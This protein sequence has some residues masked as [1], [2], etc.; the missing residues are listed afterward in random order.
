VIFRDR[1]LLRP[2]AKQER[3]ERQERKQ[4]AAHGATF[5]ARRA[6]VRC[7]IGSPSG[8]RTDRR[9]LAELF[10]GPAEFV[11]AVIRALVKPELIY[12]GDGLCGLYPLAQSN[13]L[14]SCA[15]WKRQYL[16]RRRVQVAG[17]GLR[18]RISCEP[19]CHLTHLSISAG[20]AAK[21]VAN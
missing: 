1:S 17:D 12:L 13:G 7:G 4:E 16:R 5:A 19:Y 8:K 11:N 14:S 10:L 3:E 6:E 2:A 20:H 9:C 21:C 18:H 15:S